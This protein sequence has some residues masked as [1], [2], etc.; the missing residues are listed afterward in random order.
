MG[1][2]YLDETDPS[3]G[4]DMLREYGILIDVPRLRAPPTIDGKIG[5]DE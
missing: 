5:E 3:R 1:R 2:F 4:I